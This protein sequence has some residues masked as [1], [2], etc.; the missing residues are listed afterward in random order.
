MSKVQQKPIQTNVVR[1][2]TTI[3]SEKEIPDHLK[4]TM[5]KAKKE[6][7]Q[8]IEKQKQEDKKKEA[9][10]LQQQKQQEKPEEKPQEYNFNKI[11]A[12][13]QRQNII[14]YYSAEVQRASTWYRQI[15]RLEQ[16]RSRIT[17]TGR[18]SA[19]DV[20]ELERIDEDIEYCN[21][22]I[23]EL[24]EDYYEDSE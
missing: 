12:D 10:Q 2:V 21:T 18:L 24:E 14:D 7:I 1:T 16:Q 23:A 22:V 6:S 3:K 17:R 4:Q 15:E 9:E 8:M 5:L 19:N 11:F 13:Y 20:D